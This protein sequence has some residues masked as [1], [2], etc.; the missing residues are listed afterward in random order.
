MPKINV[1]CVPL[2]LLTTKTEAGSFIEPGPVYCGQ[3]FLGSASQR[4]TVLV[5]YIEPSPQTLNTLVHNTIS[6]PSKSA[7][8]C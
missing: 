5:S 8:F 7:I 4:F 6:L 1:G 3:S 2:S